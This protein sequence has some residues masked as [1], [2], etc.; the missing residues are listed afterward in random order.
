MS[1]N[2]LYDRLIIVLIGILIPHSFYG[3]E[4]QVRQFK[5]NGQ[6][7][8]A[9]I[10]KIAQD[11]MGF[12]WFATREWVA[13]YDGYV[14]RE[15]PLP[16]A[17]EVQRDVTAICF[18]GNREV[19]IGTPLGI[20]VYDRIRGSYTYILPDAD[21]LDSK[22]NIIYDFATLPSG[23]I[24][25]ATRNGVFYLSQDQYYS[26]SLLSLFPIHRVFDGDKKSE[27]IARVLLIDRQSDIWI[28]TEG[29]GVINIDKEAAHMTHYLSQGLSRYHGD[30][31]AALYQDTKGKIWVGSSRGLYTVDKEGRQLVKFST[32]NQS[33]T[34]IVA[35]DEIDHLLVGTES[36]IYRV[37]TR[38]GAFT[39]TEGWLSGSLVNHLMADRTG[40]I[41]I[42]S[43]RGVMR[44]MQPSRFEL[45]QSGESTRHN[46]ASNS[47]SS[48]IADNQ[49]G[50]V[51]LGLVGEGVNYYNRA[52]KTVVRYDLSHLATQNSR[53]RYV[54]ALVKM[55]D[56]RL[57]AG[58]D[59]GLIVYEPN[60][61]D[62]EPF[63]FTNY[64]DQDFENV[65]AFCLDH[66]GNL[67][68]SVLDKGLYH[69]DFSSSELQLVEYSYPSTLRDIYTNIKYIYE[70]SNHHIWLQFHP[71]GVGR[72]D[73]KK[74]EISLYSRE[75]T[76]GL[77]VDN[78]INHFCEVDHK[79]MLFATDRGLSVFNLK[80]QAFESPPLAKSPIVNQALLALLPTK[81]RLWVTSDNGIYAINKQLDDWVHYLPADGLEAASFS[82]KLAIQ[83]GGALFFAGGNGLY[84]TA[85]DVAVTYSYRPSVAMVE[86]MDR[87]AVIPVAQWLD[88][89]R[90]KPSYTYWDF[91]SNLSVLVSGFSYQSEWRNQIEYRI[92]PGDT[93]WTRLETGSRRIPLSRRSSGYYWV[94]VRGAN[95]DAVWGSP[96]RVIE[97][98]VRPTWIYLLLSLLLLIIGMIPIFFQY[99]SGKFKLRKRWSKLKKCF[100]R[101]SDQISGSQVVCSS[102]ERNVLVE[103]M[104]VE[105]LYVNKRL[106]KAELATR[107]KMTETQLSTFIKESF[108]QS[109]S[110]F[111]NTYRV[112]AVKD[113]IQDPAYKNYTYMGIAEECGF[114]SKTSFFRVFKEHT[115]E[116]P[117]AYVQRVQS[118]VDKG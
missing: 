23:R 96:E 99:K 58:T 91:Q 29:D 117:S 113:R 101:Y 25:V 20:Y 97:L 51:W 42:A 106:T 38:T 35:A 9:Y 87:D 64:P 26:L 88:S 49:R 89:S 32:I 3:G 11:D 116:T 12:I 107:L 6:L 92:L 16:V 30:Q 72:Y 31:V 28:G 17:M 66:Q 60:K 73:P 52:D 110:E 118:E 81:T 71:A 13:Y 95:A 83:A 85:S 37:N 100:T 43:P 82:P 24:C 80:T 41:W 48:L 84:S 68:F 104:E 47:I 76:G 61:R 63:Y 74:Q 1:K 10:N 5:H 54:R 70:D 39:L 14:V 45:I 44:Y 2:R 102:L 111:V 4:L 114:N 98:Y 55:A 62:F 27:R 109:F 77:L 67:W 65:Y 21:N 78:K 40:M 56:G 69:Y 18:R 50:G 105:Q 22:S 19:L 115:G 8:S 79:K 108:G 53:Y 57:L 86:L 75:L 15:L 7:P 36:S 93:E 94:E 46:L 33:V 103:L 59:A 112:N 34:S 90:E